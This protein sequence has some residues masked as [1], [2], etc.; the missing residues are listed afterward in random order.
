MLAP[1]RLRVPPPRIRQPSRIGRATR[2]ETGHIARALH[3]RRV[4]GNR[5][6]SNRQPTTD[7][8]TTVTVPM[9]IC[10]EHP[11]TGARGHAGNKGA[12][13]LSM[14]TALSAL[15]MMLVCVVRACC[16]SALTAAR[17]SGI[18][19]K[20]TWTLAGSGAGSGTL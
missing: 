16:A 19:G 18:T 5:R 9:S 11:G 1:T 4:G 15:R 2:T 3:R 12:S 7:S 6:R 10:R 17:V 13:P 20:R 8:V 14:A